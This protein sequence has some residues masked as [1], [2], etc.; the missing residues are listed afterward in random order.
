MCFVLK[1][2]RLV[3]T[4][5]LASQAK[6]GD[7]VSDQRFLLSCAARA[8]RQSHMTP[9]RGATAP[10]TSHFRPQDFI[11]CRAENFNRRA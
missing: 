10:T 6:I 8:R 11:M 1:Y 4:T 3:V 7:A 5:D 2:T 9:G